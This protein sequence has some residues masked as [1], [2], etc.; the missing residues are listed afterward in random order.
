MAYLVPTPAEDVASAQFADVE[1]IHSRLKERRRMPMDVTG[2]GHGS[3]L[4]TQAV[5]KLFSRPARATMIRV[6][7]VAGNND[8][9]IHNC[10]V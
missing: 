9:R 8:S 4:S 1:L 5:Q 3:P 2:V 10:R 7:A 6:T